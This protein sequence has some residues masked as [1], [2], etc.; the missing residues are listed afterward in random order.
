MKNLKRITA[1]AAAIVMAIALI[2]HAAA[3][4]TYEY[5][6]YSYTFINNKNVSICGWDD[7]SDE[8]VIPDTISGRNVY[9]IANYACY[10]DTVISKLDLSNVTHLTR[11]GMGAFQGCTGIDQELVIPECVT[12]INMCAFQDCSSLP[13]VID[14]S[15]VTEIPDQCFYG[16]TALQSVTLNENVERIGFYAFASC[17]ALEYVELSRNINSIQASSFQNCPEL[18]LGVYYDSY[19]YTYSKDREIPYVLLDGVKLGDANG[20]DCVNVNDVTAI[21]RHVA[22][23]EELEGIYCHAAD[24]NGDGVVD[25]NDAT[26]LQ[27]FLAEYDSEYNIGQI[28]TQ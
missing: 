23:L 18:T 21:Q 11:I 9:S 5:E 6:G 16:C 26:E 12:A 22:E 7:R 19:A 13:A 1:A 24:I 15:S 20:D 14:N 3:E 4:T 17:G 2:A 10:N 25:I 28:M 27:L 8:L